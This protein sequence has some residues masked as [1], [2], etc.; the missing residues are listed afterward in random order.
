MWDLRL[1]FEH[2]SFWAGPAV[3]GDVGMRLDGRRVLVTGGSGVIGSAIARTCAAAGAD[4]VIVARREEPLRDLAGQLSDGSGRRVVA[5]PGDVGDPEVVPRIVA[6]AA[7]A[8]GGID[9]LVNNTFALGGEAPL[10]D[11]EIDDW[12][13]PWRVNVMAPFLLSKLCAPAMVERGDGRIVNVLSTA[14]FLPLSPLAPYGVTKSALW[15]LTRYLAKELAPAVRVNAVCPGSTSADGSITIESWRAALPH[16]PLGRI[17]LATE[18]AAAVLFL[19]S[20]AS[21]YTTGQ[22]LF[23]DGGRVNT[24]TGSPGGSTPATDD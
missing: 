9:V 1:A 8:L 15:T 17:G 20:D 16:V 10:V 21:S 13:E 12:D 19:A 23:V 2:A 14:A 6:D 4:V 11:L 18:T 24:V 5:V 3:S 22:N 7:E